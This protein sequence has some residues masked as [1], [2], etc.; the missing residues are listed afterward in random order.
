MEK[1][2]DTNQF[3]RANKCGTK[4]CHCWRCHLFLFAVQGPLKISARSVSLQAY[5]KSSWTMETTVLSEELRGH[6]RKMERTNGNQIWHTNQLK[7]RQKPVTPKTET[8]PKNMKQ[9]KKNNPKSTSW[10]KTGSSCYVFKLRFV[11]SNKVKSTWWINHI[12]IL[13][14]HIKNSISFTVCSC[15]YG[16]SHHGAK[17]P[18][19]L[20]ALGPLTWNQSKWSVAPPPATTRDRG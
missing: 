7:K 2:K 9:G 19:S 17:W 3:K 16:M 10:T 11:Q 14:Y 15:N 5:P 6:A 12:I 20:G 8:T 18:F 4:D 13:Q 1:I